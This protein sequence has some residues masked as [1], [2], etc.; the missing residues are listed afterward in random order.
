[1]APILPLWGME[2]H[3]SSQTDNMVV[4]KLGGTHVESPPIARR[5]GTL[6]RRPGVD[7]GR[8][9]SFQAA[10]Y[11]AELIGSFEKRKDILL[12]CNVV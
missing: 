4:L 9:A 1:M 8:G 5:R 10:G 3:N 7:S 6:R 2:C 12:N 11:L